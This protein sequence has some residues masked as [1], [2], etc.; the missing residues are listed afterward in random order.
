[1]KEKALDRDSEEASLTP[2]VAF[3]KS[4]LTSGPQFYP[5]CHGII[6]LKKILR[7]M[8]T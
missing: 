5:L 8:T 2:P 6:P 4:I 3:G 1:M 7:G